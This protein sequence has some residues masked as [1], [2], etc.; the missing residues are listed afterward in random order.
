MTVREARP[1]PHEL[2]HSSTLTWLLNAQ[3]LATLGFSF[4]D[5]IKFWVISGVIPEGSWLHQVYDWGSVWWF[6]LMLAVFYGSAGFLYQRYQHINN[7]AELWEYMR[8]EVVILMVPYLS[9]TVI[10]ILVDALAGV[11]PALSVPYLL[12][13]VFVDPV[14]SLGY[15]G[16]VLILFLITRTPRSEPAAASLMATAM[17]VKAATIIF[18]TLA[19]DLYQGIWFFARA[20]AENW[21]WFCLGIYLAKHSG[22]SLFSS[23]AL[24]LTIASLLVMYLVVGFITDLRSGLFVVSITILGLGTTFSAC[25]VAFPHGSTNRFFKTV[26]WYSMAIWLFHPPL[27]QLILWLLGLVGAATP[28]GLGGAAMVILLVT[29]PLAC[30]ILP[31]LLMKV[32]NRT[33]SFSFLLYPADYLKGWEQR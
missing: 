1:T 17:V 21:I 19:P 25:S 5:T 11:G 28:A 15:F 32:I 16:G 23:R 30:F 7:L 31:V 2:P 33:W 18:A 10:N 29:M 13:K 20:A 3:A 6:P 24:V 27:E 22:E 14:G 4:W 9:F 12:Q 8:Y 26:G